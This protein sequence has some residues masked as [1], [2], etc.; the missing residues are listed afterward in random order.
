M[1][2]DIQ[3]IRNDFPILHQKVNHKRLVYLDN[4]A[5][6]QKPVQVLE[7]II[8]YYSREN[9]NVHRGVHTLSQVA[10]EAYEDARKTTAKFLGANSPE[11]IIFTRGTTEGM[12]FLAT[13]LE[14]MMMEGDNIVVT[15]ME[16][17]S[18]L[19]PWQQ[20]CKRTGARLRVAPINDRGELDLEKLKSLIDTSTKIVSVAHI[21]NVLGTINPVKEIATMAHEL[22]AFIVIDGAQATAHTNIDVQELDCDFYAISAHKAYGPTGIGALYGR[23]DWLEKLQPYHF[24]GEMVDQVGFDEAT[25]NV[26]PFKFEAGTPN[27]AGAIGMEAALNFITEIGIENIREYEDEVLDYATNQ[28][29]SIDGLKLVG[30]AENKTAVCSFVID[31]VH[32]YDLGTLLDQMGIAIRTGHHCAQ[33]LI[34][35][36]G[37][38]GTLRASFAIYNTM[39][40]VDIFVAAL[41]K[42]VTMLR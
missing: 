22:G 17:H 37:L 7:R 40:E 4:A 9:S 12:N 6:T 1:P 38:S 5:T 33:P 30:E 20:L 21:S 14:P 42:A 13:V 31:G 28:L 29:K 36:M 11:E 24:G 18:N 10:T 23:K 34:E 16:H 35:S 2:A 27:V 8:E 25:F 15:A 41:Q 32:P 19:V 3:K 26:L 39:E